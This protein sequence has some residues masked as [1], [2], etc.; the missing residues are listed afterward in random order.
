MARIDIF[1]SGKTNQRPEIIRFGQDYG[2][3][4]NRNSPSQILSVSSRCLGFSLPVIFMAMFPSRPVLRCTHA[5]VVATVLVQ[6]LAQVVLLL[7]STVLGKTS[8]PRLA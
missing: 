3:T 6:I 5:N 7:A 1:F 2:V 4:K 8:L